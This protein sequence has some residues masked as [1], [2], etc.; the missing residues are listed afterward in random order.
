MRPRLAAVSLAIAFCALPPSMRSAGAARAIS[1]CDPKVIT[2]A[3]LAPVLSAPIKSEIP[4]PGDAQT[5]LFE[6]ASYSQVTISLRPG[7]GKSSIAAAVSGKTN[8][9][10]TDVPGVGDHAVWDSFAQEV[11]AEKN[12]LLCDITATGPDAEGATAAK[13]GAICNKIFAA[14]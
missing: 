10:V 11:L 5:C 7:L 12:D 9:K 1:A 4:L 3:D 8:Q 2:Q 13:L 14:Q 6:T